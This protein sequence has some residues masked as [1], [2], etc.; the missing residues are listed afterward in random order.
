[1]SQVFAPHVLELD[2]ERMEQQ[3]L[4]LAQEAVQL[5]QFQQFE[6]ALQRATLAAQLAPNS[7]QVWLLLGRLYLQME[8]Y[9][10]SVDAILNARELDDEDP[11]ALFDLGSVYFRL[12]EFSKAAEALEQG[13]EF[14]PGVPGALFDLGNTYFMLEQYNDAI[15]QYEKAVDIDDTFWPA[16]NNIG[17]VLYEKG[18]RNDAIDHWQEA[19]ELTEEQEAEPLLA[20]AVALYVEGEESEAIATGQTALG[21]DSRYADLEFLKEN[22]WGDRLLMDTQEFLTLPMIQEALVPGTSSVLN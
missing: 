5:A 6:L 22:L 14:A 2:A 4:F 9:E 11:A 20:I 3:G 17:L 1:M 7:P 12:G 13:L 19:A 10:Q 18:D 8:D 21:I 16:V 15:D